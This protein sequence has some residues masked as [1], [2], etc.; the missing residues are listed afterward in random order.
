MDNYDSVVRQMEAFGVEWAGKDLP[1]QVPTLKRKTCGMKGKWWY[2]LQ[3]WRPRSPD[4]VETGAE[5]VVGK[6]GSYKHG[7]SE[8]KVEIDFKPP[9]EAERARFRAERA[10]AREV[11]ATAKLEAAAFAAL[12]AREMWR[13]A[14]RVGQSPYLRRKGVEGEACRYFADGTVVIPLLR[15]DVPSPDSLRAVQRIHPDGF[16][17]F[18]RGFSKAGCA[19]RLGSVD[20]LT[21]ALIMVSE[22]YATGLTVRAATLRRFP[23]YVALDAYNLAHVVPI[24]RALHPQAWILICADDDWISEDHHGKNPGRRAAMAVARTT[25]RC[26]IVMP[27]F[28]PSTRQD[29]DTD[30]N[31]LQAR[32][33]LAVVE[34]QLMAVVSGIQARMGRAR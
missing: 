29:K 22:G 7:G 4:G 13:R 10:A 27:L 15:Y 17:V 8:Q 20:Q 19:L 23:L 12:D 5:Y 34:R 25:E 28:N 21:T 9:T 32:E 11:A 16:K 33:G 3:L 1:L 31:D 24:L 14:S 6:F 30:F 18:T 2:W 26:D